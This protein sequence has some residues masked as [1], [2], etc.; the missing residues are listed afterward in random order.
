MILITGAA[1]KT[2]RAVI[3]ALTAKAQPT[4]GLVYRPEQ[5]T[6]PERLGVRDVVVG[7]MRVRAVM[8][9]AFNGVRAVYHMAPNMHPEEVRI[10][11][12]AIEAARSAG[13]EHFVYHSVLHPQT[14]AMPHHWL[15]LRVEEILFASGLSYTI[16]QPAAYMQ[17]VQA[18]WNHIVKRGLYPVPYAAETQ[19][20]MV[21]LQ[22]VAEVASKVLTESGHEGATYELSGPEVLS[23]HETAEILERQLE[24][25]V[26]VEVIPLDVW[27]QQALASGLG[28]YQIETL[29]NMF[30]YYERNGFW[31]N[32]GVLEWLL[33]RRPTTFAEYVQRTIANRLN[34]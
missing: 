24:R 8:D 21:D 31:G 16:L 14:E 22:D 33:G 12:V 28:D 30:E 26:R 20:S 1:G 9:R 15:K 13:V 32:S 7:D 3:R 10:G 27:R 17:N 25:T 4:R 23:Q 5:V 29:V 34:T 6:P 2:G 19:V 18:H 11:E